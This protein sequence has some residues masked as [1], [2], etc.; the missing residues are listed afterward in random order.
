MDAAPSDSV[1]L[2]RSEA[3]NKLPIVAL[4]SPLTNGPV[5]FLLD[6]GSTINLISEHVLVDG[7]QYVPSNVKVKT[8]GEKPITMT[9]SLA[10]VPLMKGPATIATQNF[11]VTSSKLKDFDGILG[12]PFLTSGKASL[13]FASQQLK[14]PQYSLPFLRFI[15]SPVVHACQPDDS[16]STEDNVMN[17]LAVE[18]QSL[19]TVPL[20]LQRKVEFPPTSSGVIHVQGPRNFANRTVV[21]EPTC[22]RNHLLIGS[23]VLTLDSSSQ[24]CLPAMNVLPKAT[25]L[26]AHQPIGEA[27]AISDPRLFIGAVEPFSEQEY[28]GLA[29]E[30]LW[31]LE[32]QHTREIHESGSLGT[33]ASQ[34]SRE[35]GGLSEGLRLASVPETTDSWTEGTRQENFWQTGELETDVLPRSVHTG[36]GT[37]PGTRR[38]SSPMAMETN[39]SQGRIDGLQGIASFALKTTVDC[40]KK[41]S[42]SHLLKEKEAAKTAVTSERKI[43]NETFDLLREL[44]FEATDKL[45]TTTG[46][47]KVDNKEAQEII[48]Q[49]VNNS[50]CPSHLLPQLKSLLWKYKRV[51]AKSGDPVGL[52][53]AYKPEIKLDT[54]EPIY[55]PQYLVPYKMRQTMRETT[56][57][58]LKQGIVQPSTSP[59][60]SPSL[61]VPKRDGGYRMVIDFRKLNKHVL[62]DPHPLPRIQQILETLGSAVIFTAL[63]LLHGFYN[64]EIAE[65]DRGKTAFSTYEG[66]YQ[67]IRLPMGLKNSPSVFQR[68]MQIVL[69][70]CLGQYAF[71]YIDDILVFSKTPT[72]HLKHLGDVLQRLDKAGLRIKASKCQLWRAEVEYLGF[73]AGRQGL[74][75]NPRKLDS[76]KQFPVPEKVRDVQAFLGLVGYF[77]IFVKSFANRAEPLH[78]LLRKTTSWEWTPACQA[79]F[80]DLKQCMLKAPILAF[81]D[82]SKP[83]ILTTDASG[84]AIGA[85]L[86][87]LQQ[88]KE[89]LIACTS[90]TLTKSEKNYSNPDRETLAVVNG[91]EAFKS[92][93]WGNKFTIYTDNS[94]I[95]AIAKQEHSTNRRAI[96][97]YTLL[98]EYDFDLQHRKANT[99]QHADA[100]SRYPVQSKEKPA[101]ALNY[102]SPGMQTTDFLPILDLDQWRII[103]QYETAPP[104]LPDDDKYKMEQNFSDTMS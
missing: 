87:Q 46:K 43:D 39:R 79:A 52:C 10:K 89:R 17:H 20:I 99:M 104:A 69:S 35:T 3:L 67:F 86:T 74:R 66:H 97:W 81:P 53:T 24:G 15:D 63:D 59:Y 92:Y 22:V 71:I 1:H 72:D 29:P 40:Q 101:E 61:M 33:E 68:L 83:F 77:R 4:E 102:L 19:P 6:S 100:L 8:L 78:Y 98:S 103:E 11:L 45:A 60:N 84:Y 25:V 2:I 9:G 27:Y 28:Y 82:F 56:L 36:A 64:L 21:M 34:D 12:T 93:L 13:C 94:A 44:E 54:N 48:E 32:E 18:M 50:E 47:I 42:T 76:I 57:D 5:L 95:S 96:R 31:H 80:D 7:L 91:V 38:L 16:C 65:K 41:P 58:F 55:T 70:G 37:R 88:G 26:N 14:T 23:T 73:I 85:V 75:V 62:T 51:L 30:Q 90:R 49:M